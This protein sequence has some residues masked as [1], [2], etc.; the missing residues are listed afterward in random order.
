M[1]ILLLKGY[2]NYF[3]RIHKQESS[4][5]DYKEASTSYLEYPNV[6]F[7]PQDGIMT[8]LVV[9]SE[10]QKIVIPPQTEGGSS[11]TK[12]LNFDEAGSPDYLIVY[13]NLPLANGGPKIHSRWF[14]LEC[15]KVRQGQYKLALKRDLITD[16][17]ESIMKSP[18]YV[19]KGYIS[20][21]NN[22]LLLNSEGMKFNQIKQSENFIKDDS[23][24]AWLVGY[25]K[26]N[27]DNSD[28][29]TV[30]PIVYT[31]PGDSTSIPAA[32]SFDWEPCIEYINTSGTSITASPKKCFYFYNS[33]ISFRTWY[34]PS[35]FSIMT[36]NVRT[37]F[38]ENYQSLYSSTDFP[39]ED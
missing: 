20:D 14:I 17:N 37:K 29:S 24:C 38:T 27:I 28:L 23:H 31:T 16:F 10:T 12:V 4:I 26:K 39:N 6:N 34:Q 1:T 19:E 15:V 3:N 36:G 35:Y 5:T 33:D 7:D 21:V 13:E 18:C 22:P 25:V 2:N 32:G 30:N 9:G 11:T 8:S